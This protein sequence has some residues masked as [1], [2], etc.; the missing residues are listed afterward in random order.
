ME[1]LLV[2]QVKGIQ[3]YDEP[4][5]LSGSHLLGS[6]PPQMT[7][8]HNWEIEMQAHLSMATSNTDTL[9]LAPKNAHCTPWHKLSHPYCLQTCGLAFLSVG[10]HISQVIHVAACVRPEGLSNCI[11]LPLC[12]LLLLA[13]GSCQAGDRGHI[14][15]ATLPGQQLEARASAE[16]GSR[17]GSCGAGAG[18]V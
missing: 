3:I 5:C 13:T 15:T 6:C 9:K 1:L 14:T 7:Y 12:T 16:S 11:C 2:Q 18:L 4:G 8:V 10:F 17:W